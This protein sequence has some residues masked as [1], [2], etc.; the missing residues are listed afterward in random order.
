MIRSAIFTQARKLAND[1][2][3]SDPFHTDTELHALM[4]N[5]EIKVGLEFKFPRKSQTIVFTAG[6][7]GPS[8]TKSLDSDFWGIGPVFFNP[9]SA[10]G[11]YR[12]QPRTEAEMEAQDPDWR[13]LGSALPSY[14]IIGDSISPTAAAFPART[15]TTERA[16]SETRTM[17]IYGHQF[18]AAATDAT[19]GPVVPASFHEGAVYY[20]AWLMMMPRNKNDAGTYAAMFK[21]ELRKVKTL[22]LET[23]DTESNVWDTY[24]E[25]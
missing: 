10:T 23:D 4:D 7:G 12:L 6:Q 22:T 24:Q 14:Y 17:R 18:P 3:T 20:L 1:S 11:G 5:F 21:A 15:I 8:S 2:D 16:T 9:A 25:S 13:Q 19:K